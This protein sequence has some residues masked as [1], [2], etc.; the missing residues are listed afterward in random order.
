MAALLGCASRPCVFARAKHKQSPMCSI[1]WLPCRASA[2]WRGASE[3]SSTA[4]LWGKPTDLPWGFGVPDA[5]GLLMARHPS[6]LYEAALEGLVLFA[7]LW[8]FTG[9][10]RPRLAPI[11]LFFILYGCG[12]FTVE[13]V[14][15]PDANIGYLAGDWLT[16]GMLL[17]TP[18]D[19]H[20]AA[21]MIYAYR[22]NQTS[23]NWLRS[24]GL[25]MRQYLDFLRHIRDTG[26]RKEDRTGT[27]TLSVFGY[28]MRFDLGKGFPLV[29][30][31]KLHLQQVAGSCCLPPALKIPD[32]QEGET[33][34]GT[35]RS[36]R[37][38]QARTSVT[39]SGWRSAENCRTSTAVNA[40]TAMNAQS[41][42]T[43]PR[44]NGKPAA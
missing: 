8:W 34:S 42:I 1:S 25:T 22:R 29:T 11:G 12:R 18:D 24:R 10:P 40:N 37:K 2:C 26:A 20:R 43:V 35:R 9:K 3:I 30:T 4:S 15:L 33:G 14:R 16:M 44:R 41:P 7:I 5:E 27:G 21:M 6:Q 17:T 39:N 28:Q 23:G 38:I 13:W 19:P 36:A 32:Q 31:K